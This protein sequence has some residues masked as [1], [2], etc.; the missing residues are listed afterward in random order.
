ML[1]VYIEKNISCLEEDDVAA[2]EMPKKYL[3]SLKYI[4]QVEAALEATSDAHVYLLP[5][6]SQSQFK[7]DC[8]LYM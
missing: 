7:S 3:S 6:L 4:Y 1:H 2:N 8:N 5:M